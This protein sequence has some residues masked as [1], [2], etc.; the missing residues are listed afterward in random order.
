[1]G[2]VDD[3]WR[4]PVKSMRGEQLAIAHVFERG[5]LGD[6][7]YALLDVASGLV[8]SASNA[9]EFPTILDCQATFVEPPQAGVEPP[10]VRITLPDGRSASNDSTGFGPWLSAYFR[11]DVALVRTVPATYSA[12]Q[13]AYFT[14]LGLDLHAPPDSFV[15]LCPVSLMSTATL[16]SL[17]EAGRG[18]RFDR[19]R[20]RMNLI[21]QAEGH[22][23]VENA[24]LHHQLSVGPALRITI[25]IPDPRCVVTTLA[26][27]ELEKDPGVL[28]TLARVNSRT[29]GTADALPCAGVYASVDHPGPIG[30]GDAVTIL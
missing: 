24:W 20:F 17:G 25:T 27:A 15:D 2:L 29:V 10:P 13:A 21:V 30:P 28:R 8:V 23:F 18:S 3:L 1:M 19:R 14:R 16:A 11:R 26:Q 9:K 5:V 12:A 7:A 6:R 22:G 4:Y